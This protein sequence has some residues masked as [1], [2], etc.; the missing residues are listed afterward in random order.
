MSFATSLATLFVRLCLRRGARRSL[1]T[2]CACVL[3][4]QLRPLSMQNVNSKY[5]R[6][7]CPQPTSAAVELEYTLQRARMVR[8]VVR[9]ATCSWQ[10]MDF[11]K[12]AQWRLGLLVNQVLSAFSRL[13]LKT[14]FRHRH[15]TALYCTAINRHMLCHR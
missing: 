11:A 4:Q 6:P 12:E 8:L 2:F 5:C 13:P 7:T 14:A 3:E 10:A 15:C 9:N 1:E